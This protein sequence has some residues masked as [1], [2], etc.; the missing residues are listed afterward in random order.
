MKVLI[1]TPSYGGTVT[2]EY[3]VSVINLKAVLAAHGIESQVVFQNLAE[4]IRVRNYFATKMLESP[5]FTHL[6]FVDADM[7]FRHETVLHMLAFEKSV[8]GCL[9][10]KRVL[11]SQKLYQQ[12]QEEGSFERNYARTVEFVGEAGVRLFAQANQESHKGG[13]S[14][15]ELVG[16]R[17]ARS[18]FAG[19]GLMLIRRDVF[20]IIKDMCSDLWLDKVSGIYKQWGLESGVLQCFE[21]LRGEDG[22]FAS[23]DIS[24]CRRWTE[25]CGGEIWVD[26]KDEIGHMGQIMVQSAFLNRVNK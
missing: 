2:T 26:V 14:Q 12:A 16:G 1:A 6:L 22:V 8:V 20:S 13:L 7:Q 18:T 21:S 4:I 24:F 9:Y 10:P 17:F 19:T 5:D 23:E 15:L 25:I 11:D 3:A